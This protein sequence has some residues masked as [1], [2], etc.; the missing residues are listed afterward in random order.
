LVVVVVAVAVVVK[1]KNHQE[2]SLE[3]V[4]ASQDVQVGASRQHEQLP[5]HEKKQPYHVSNYAFPL[6]VHRC[7]CYKYWNASKSEET[8]SYFVEHREGSMKNHPFVAAGGRIEGEEDK[9]LGNS[10]ERSLGQVQEKQRR[11][12]LFFLWIPALASVLA[13]VVVA[14]RFEHVLASFVCVHSPRLEPSQSYQRR[15]ISLNYEKLQSFSM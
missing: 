2:A 12:R 8:Q 15:Q 1:D 9:V 5:S 14:A 3:D 7:I 11:K 4:V 6:L 10:Q 13:V